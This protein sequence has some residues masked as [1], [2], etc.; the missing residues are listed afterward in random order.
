MV[1]NALNKSFV[2]NCVIR[3]I[4]VTKSNEVVNDRLSFFNCVISDAIYERKLRFLFKMKYSDNML[5]S[6]VM[7]K[8]CSCRTVHCLLLYLAYFYFSLLFSLYLPHALVNK[9]GYIIA[10]LCWILLMQE[11]Q[12]LSHPPVPLLWHWHLAARQWASSLCASV[13]WVTAMWNS[14][15]HWSNGQ[16]L[17]T[18]T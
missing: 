5:F 3:K 8:T 1:I 4:F 12:S 17:M 2:L 6:L 15:V 14:W 16:G 11:M 13:N 18:S 10:M 9:A 7:N